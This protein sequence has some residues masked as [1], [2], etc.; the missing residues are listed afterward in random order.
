MGM[1]GIV[2]V[3]S[4]EV[5]IAKKGVAEEREDVE[6]W[7]IVC[8]QDRGGL[9]GEAIYY[10]DEC[11]CSPERKGMHIGDEVGV[12]GDSLYDAA[13]REQLWI[14]ME[15]EKMRQLWRKET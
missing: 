4:G 3:D 10:E 14:G 12:F 11:C 13:M 8:R 1:V 6:G 2:V 7:Q 15:R 5:R 9:S